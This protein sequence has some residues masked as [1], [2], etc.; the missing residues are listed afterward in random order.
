MVVVDMKDD[1]GRLRFKPRNAA[2]AAKGASSTPWTWSPCLHD[3]GEGYGSSRAWWSSRTP[4]SPRRK[5]AKY[6]VWD[7]KER[8]RPWVGYTETRQKKTAPAGAAPGAPGLA[9]APR[10]PQE[11]LLPRPMSTR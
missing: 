10:Q 11:R 8:T 6:A 7:A 3:E 5:A 4:S 1:Y 2:V 9:P